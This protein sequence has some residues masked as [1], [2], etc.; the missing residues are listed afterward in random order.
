MRVG[1]ASCYYNH[2]YGS[3]LQAYATQE[4]VK[5][6][7]CEAVTIQ[8]NTP[9]TYML[10]S[11]SA[12]LI[13]KI[14]NFGIFKRKIREKNAQKRLEKYPEIAEYIKER[15]V[16]FDEFWKRHIKLSDLCADR[17]ELKEF[18]D[19]L[20]AVVV[21]SDM[22]WH[23]INV[24][25]DYFTLSFVPEDVKKIS[26]AT[27][28]GTTVIPIN[29]RYKY[30]D[31]LNRFYAISVRESSGVSVIDDLGVK[32]KATVVLDPTLLFTGDEWM[33]IQEDMPLIEEKYILCYFLGVN[34]EHRHFA[35]KLRTVTGY[36]I[37][38]LLHLDEFV[39][40]DLEYADITPYN[41]GPSEFINLIR[42]AKFICTDSFH[43]TCFS[44]LNHK[45]F[46]TFNRFSEDNSQS[47]NT[48]IDSLLRELG[49]ESRRVDCMASLNDIKHILECN[50][51]YSNVDSILDYERKKSVKF[52]KDALNKE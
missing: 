17:R 13:H 28:F 5:K 1:I 44:V 36:K 6:I 20:D 42:H 7:G 26:Y 16:L 45:S 2:N 23:P 18:S 47:T 37:V 15:D 22:L 4:I 48:R 30:I 24:E 43:G 35:E 8:C 46:F 27:S 41:V 51:N 50:I 40:D 31:F 12:Y 49:L 38:A 39:E 25:H 21:G 33:G 14:F 9:I 11:R 34:K 19:V 3:M 10:Q 29:M 32:K 52:L